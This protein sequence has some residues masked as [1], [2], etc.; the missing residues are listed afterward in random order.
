MIRALV[1]LHKLSKNTGLMI[2]EFDTA[3]EFHRPTRTK[4][5]RGQTIETFTYFSKDMAKV[6]YVTNRE[7]GV[8]RVAV[9][10]GATINIHYRSDITAN[11]RIK[12]DAK[13][14]KIES[15][16]PDRR[17]MMQIQATEVI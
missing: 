12:I 15:M 8:E 4:S 7:S 3:I 6:D 9:V 17:W 5:D 14:F 10:T 13:F 16:A 2:G 1:W 11:D